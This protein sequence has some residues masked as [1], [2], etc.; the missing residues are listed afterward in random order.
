[1]LNLIK[2]R[3]EIQILIQKKKINQISFEDKFP[4]GI[5]IKM[6]CIILF[7][8]KIQKNTK[9]LCKFRTKKEDMLP[10]NDILKILKIIHEFS[11]LVK[12]LLF[13]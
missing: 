13:I 4:R 5:K 10:I 7:L 6:T 3:V 1:M 2:W 8:K 11:I 12:E 9:K